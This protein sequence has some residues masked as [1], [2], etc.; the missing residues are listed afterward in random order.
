M[1]ELKIDREKAKQAFAE[2][3]EKYDS[4]DEK[5]RLKIEHTYKVA[6]ICEQIALAEQLEERDVDLAWLLGLLHDVGRF[7]QLRLYGTFQDAVSVDHAECGADILFKDGKIRD[8]ITGKSEDALIEK[9][10]RV[11][12]KFR[13]PGELEKRE[14][15]YAN[16]LRDADKIDILRVNVET[17]MEKIY[18]VTTQEL[19]T[20]SVSPEVMRAFAERHAV[21]RDVMQTSVDHL[22]GHIALVYELVFPVSRK[23]VKEQG[24]LD[25]MMKFE[26]ENSRTRSDF[27]RICMAMKAYL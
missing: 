23:I 22:V 5:V 10:I 25:K 15:F 8:Y 26:S 20:A 1:T 16:L 18:D 12:N 2:Y 11:H 14:V 27:W 13:I 9:A 7:E 3:T 6:D 17:P 21:L 4:S 19:R 24:Y